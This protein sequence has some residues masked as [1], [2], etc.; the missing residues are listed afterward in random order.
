MSQWKSSVS[1]GEIVERFNRD[2]V[3]LPELV[4][5]IQEEFR[6]NPHYEHA[7]VRHATEALA[8]MHLPAETRAAGLGGRERAA[9]REILGEVESRLQ[10][11]ERVC[12]KDNRIYVSRVLRHFEKTDYNKADCEILSEAVRQFRASLAGT[13]GANAGDPDVYPLPAASLTSSRSVTLGSSEPA[14]PGE[15]TDAPCSG[16]QEV[17]RAHFPL[18]G[19]S[20]G[21]THVDG[22]CL[23][24]ITASPSVTFHPER[25]IVPKDIAVDFLVNEIRVGKNSQL[26]SVGALPAVMFTEKAVGVRLRMDAVPPSMLVTIGVTNQSPDARCFRGTLVGSTVE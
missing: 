9:Y 19:L 5:A 6:E 15:T 25:L 4:A 26:M 16:N 14:P 2:E 8:D 23:A 11:L 20:L 18:Y 22:H 13:A 12:S 7:D 21:K 3:T 24:Y 10:Q 1:L 17:A